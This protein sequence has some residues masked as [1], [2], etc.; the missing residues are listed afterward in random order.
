MPLMAFKPLLFMVAYNLNTME[1]GF[2]VGLSQV[3]E[4][5]VLSCLSLSCKDILVY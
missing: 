5:K 3:V 1:T 2:A 4:Q